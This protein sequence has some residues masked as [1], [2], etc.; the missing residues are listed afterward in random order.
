M[1]PAGVALELV[2]DAEVLELEY[3]NGDCVLE[4]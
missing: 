4:G 1:L 3:Q 2:G